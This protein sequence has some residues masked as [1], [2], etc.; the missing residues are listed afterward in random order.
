MQE[1]NI[2]AVS[3]ISIFKLVSIGLFFSLMPALVVVGIL[4]GL[5]ILSMNY[6]GEILHGWWPVVMGPIFGLSLVAT[7]TA[8]LGTAMTLGLWA[9]SLLGPTTIS[10]KPFQE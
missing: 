5:G 9:Y 10:V 7:L 2:K 4:C 8:F 3:P 1:L 6:N